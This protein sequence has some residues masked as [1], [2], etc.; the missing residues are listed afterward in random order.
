MKKILALCFAL[1][2]CAALLAPCSFTQ[3]TKGRGGWNGG[4]VT[5]AATFVGNTTF[6]ATPLFNNGASFNSGTVNFS[7][8]TVIGL[9]GDGGV[10]SLAGRTGAVTLSASDIGSGTFDDARIPLLDATKISSG[11]LNAARLGS[12]THDNTTFLRGDG[13]WAMPSSSSSWN[14][15]T[16]TGVTEFDQGQVGNAVKIVGDTVGSNTNAPLKV[17]RGTPGSASAFVV[18]DSNGSTI[19]FE[20]TAKGTLR[21]PSYAFST[22]PSGLTGGFNGTFVYCS[23]CTKATPCASGGTG[24]MAKRLNGA[25]DCN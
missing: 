15:G 2:M 20:V 14:G 22:L 19:W 10:T 16:V 18:Y 6:N 8:A 7:G 11:T 5:N 3:T 17:V 12:G 25:W 21:P 1:I 9:S 13:T 4:L 23:D 24:A